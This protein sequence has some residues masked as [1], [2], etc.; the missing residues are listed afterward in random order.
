M[1]VFCSNSCPQQ[2]ALALDD[3]RLIKLTLE[4]TQMLS[5]SRPHLRLL[6]PAFLNHPATKW[7]A[8]SDDNYGWLWRHLGFLHLEYQFRYGK[9]HKLFTHF[10]LL[11][12]LSSKCNPSYFVKLTRDVSR[13]LDY[14]FIDDVHLS[15]REYL[16]GKWATDKRPV[17]WTKRG[18]PEWALI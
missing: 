3:K 10:Q 18:K 16:R 9:E 4:S 15:Y 12:P 11:E 2:S 13:G 8:E 7:V 5:S 6:K 1:N 17:Y 14:T